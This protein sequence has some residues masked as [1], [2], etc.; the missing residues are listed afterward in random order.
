MLSPVSSGKQHPSPEPVFP[1]LESLDRN[2]S[3]PRGST[4]TSLCLHFLCREMG[5]VPPASYGYCRGHLLT[6]MKGWWRANEMRAV[7]G[8]PG[9]PCPTGS[10]QGPRDLHIH[11]LPCTL[12][13]RSAHLSHPRTPSLLLAPQ[14]PS[15]VGRQFLTQKQ[16]CPFVKM[17]HLESPT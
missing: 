10:S 1:L 8:P 14:Q 6:R 13:P 2:S 11:P 15:I 16:F 12:W 4:L 5:M 7:A 3:C 17:I 9:P